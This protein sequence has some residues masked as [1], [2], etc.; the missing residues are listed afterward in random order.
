[1]TLS[2]L[3]RR[4]RVVELF[5]QIYLITFAP[6]DLERS[7]LAEWEYFYGS[8]M[9]PLEGAGPS[10]PKILGDSLR[11]YRLTWSDQIWH[12]NVWVEGVCFDK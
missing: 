12:G 1:M 9:P 11:P 6:L 8:V 7:R 4:T 2:D 5:Q 10:V 3:E